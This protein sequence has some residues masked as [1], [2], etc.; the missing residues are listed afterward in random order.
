LK[1]LKELNRGA[2]RFAAAW[3]NRGLAE[4]QLKQ[5]DDAIA[6]LEY[7]VSMLPERSA[8]WLWL[9]KAYRAAGHDQQADQATSRVRGVSPERL[10]TLELDELFPDAPTTDLPAK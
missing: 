4:F 7:A 1:I 2:P 5:Y 9:S 6:S 10:D 3:V 8:V